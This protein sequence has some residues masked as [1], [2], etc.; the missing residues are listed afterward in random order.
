M[1]K[2]RS[3]IKTLKIFCVLSEIIIGLGL[4]AMVV[5]IPFSESM[6]D[7]RHANMG[8][9]VINGTP[10]WSF[11]ARLPRSTSG[12][13]SYTGGTTAFTE[14]LPV[15][16]SELGDISV[17][18]FRMNEDEGAYRATSKDIKPQ[19]IV[20]DHIEGTVT[21]KRPE[22]ATQILASIKWPFVVTML[23]TGCASLAILELL[24]RMFKSVERGE[25]FSAAN[26]QNV[27]AIGFLL[28]TSSILKFIAV[29]WLVDRMATY[30]TQHVA[31]KMTLAS[32]Y[33]GN[34]SGL[35]TGFVILALAEVFRQ[36]LRLKEDTQ[37][38]I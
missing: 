15:P 19:A 10:A 1:N 11:Y 28:V 8:L 36:G 6:V 33:E 17:G 20:I 7:S 13:I 23:C 4:V 12:S 27:R 3:L 34:L 38:T 35:G 26:I 9:F 30:V 32:T 16:N 29:G 22:N 21:F 18:P 31:G 25:I 5:S 37:F 24:R 2:N 14:G